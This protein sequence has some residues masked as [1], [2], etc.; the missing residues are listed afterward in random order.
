MTT[1]SENVQATGPTDAELASLEAGAPVANELT[2]DDLLLRL[3]D[4]KAAKKKIDNE[5]KKN[6]KSVS[7]PT[8]PAP[9]PVHADLYA[10]LPQPTEV[11]T[12]LVL[13]YGTQR[14]LCCGGVITTH[15]GVFLEYSGRRNQRRLVRLNRREIGLYPLL[16]RRTEA[17]PETVTDFCHICWD[18][19]EALVFVQHEARQL[20]LFDPKLMPETEENNNV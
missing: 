12:A 9:K 11:A 18:G 5:R 1:T 6:A 19:L 20:P 7:T 15:T 4:P 13:V 2:I 16:P 14:C 3:G 8:P 17:Q 10:P